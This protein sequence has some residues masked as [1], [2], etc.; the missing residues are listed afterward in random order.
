MSGEASSILQML[1][2]HEFMQN[3]EP[4][5]I[6]RI[7]HFTEVHNYHPQDYL[8]RAGEQAGSCLLIREGVV[9]LELYDASRGGIS[10]D[11]LNGG[12]VLGWSWLV[13]PY[14]WCFDARAAQ[15]TRVLTLNGPRLQEMMDDD[16]EF[17]YVFLR[18]FVGLFAERLHAAR[19]QLLDMYGPVR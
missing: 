4:A 10:L 17:G 5:W 18:S 2:E 15:F 19:L 11:T 14:R 9:S 3:M 16:H 7:A 13:P 12:K 6:E 1:R 8:F